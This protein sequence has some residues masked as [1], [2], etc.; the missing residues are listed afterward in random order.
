[1]KT[2]TVAATPKDCVYRVARERSSLF[3]LAKNREWAVVVKL[4]HSIASLSKMLRVEILSPFQHRVD[5]L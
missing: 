5:A 3:T 1:M 4:I 2:Y